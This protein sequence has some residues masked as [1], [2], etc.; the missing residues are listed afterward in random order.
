MALQWDRAVDMLSEAFGHPQLQGHYHLWWVLA[1][2]GR[3]KPCPILARRDDDGVRAWAGNPDAIPA[4]AHPL[5]H[6]IELLDLIQGA[7]RLAD[8]GAG[9]DASRLQPA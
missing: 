8:S 4:D 3:G 2:G 5:E 1:R 6:A 7:R 9:R